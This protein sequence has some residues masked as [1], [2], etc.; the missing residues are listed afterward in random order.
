MD[1]ANVAIVERKKHRDAFH[2]FHAAL[3]PAM[4]KP[5]LKMVEAWEADQ[6]KPNPFEVPAQG[7]VPIDDLFYASTGLLTCD[8]DGEAMRKIRKELAAEDE[9]DVDDDIDLHRDISPSQFIFQGLEIEDSQCV[10][11]LP[12]F[13]DVC[14]TL[15]R[16]RRRLALDVKG[17]PTKTN[18]EQSKIDQRSDALLR[19]IGAWI[20]I[21]NLYMTSVAPH[22]RL[23][24]ESDGEE[25]EAHTLPLFLPSSCPH[26]SIKCSRR[27]LRY[28]FQLRLAQAQATLNDLRGTLLRRSRLVQSK[29]KYGSGTVQITRSN[30]LIQEVYARANEQAKKYN[31]I[32][33]CLEVLGKALDEQRWSAVF[34]PLADSDL[35]G[36]TAMD[37]EIWGEGKK[38]L[39]WIWKV[40]GMSTDVNANPD[41]LMNLSEYIRYHPSR[42]EITFPS[43]S[44]PR[45]VVPNSSQVSPLAGGM[46]A[47]VGGNASYGPIFGVGRPTMGHARTGRGGTTRT[48]R[49]A[50][51]SR[52]DCVCTQAV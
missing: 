32:R 8:S 52:S 15:I 1:R 43:H 34:L 20:E 2:E 23:R 37:V 10:H 30:K 39:T 17:K 41:D 29:A 51:H 27:L 3:G 26:L 14:Q 9:M 38:T 6:D 47:V 36:P 24:D 45:R 7:T 11:C 49:P 44:S 46:Y 22:R 48:G 40:Q 42:H 19:K 31:H 35:K 21:Q 28:E 25:D 33:A 4:T 5:W 13:L 50:L 16:S 12:P 18:H